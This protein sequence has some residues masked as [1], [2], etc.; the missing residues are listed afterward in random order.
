MKKLLATLL[1]LLLA[2]SLVACGGDVET[3]SET[4]LPTETE[5]ETE[6]E[7]VDTTESETEADTA[8]TEAPADPFEER[9]ETVY[10]NGANA[11]NIR[12]TPSSDTSDN[13]VGSV[14]EGSPLERTGYTDTWSRVVYNGVVC[15]AS[16]KYLSVKAP[17]VVDPVEHKTMYVKVEVSL[18]V[19]SKPWM[20]AESVA[21]FNN[22]RA[23]TLTGTV[24]EADEHGIVWARISFTDENGNAKE[25]F[26]NATYLSE[27]APLAFTD[28]DQTVFV[29]CES[30]KLRSQPGGN[31]LAVAKK[32]DT[33][34]RVGVAVVADED[35][36]VW[37]KLMYNGAP[38]YAS[39]AYLALV[40]ESKTFSVD[41]MNIN[42]SDRFTAVADPTPYTAGFD[43]DDMAITV[44]KETFAILTDAGLDINMSLVTYAQTII[45]GYGLTATV[46][47]DNGQTYFLYQSPVE[48]GGTVSILAFVYKSADAYW[49]V[50]FLT[51]ASAFTVEKATIFNYAAS[52]NFN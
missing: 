32:G 45:A 40:E 3:E 49:L 26:V 23:V 52:V 33:F 7:A 35:G 27:E 11:L 29:T 13:I 47:E 21:Y 18:T 30:L 9:S 28:V 41:G 43:S 24:A 19:R 12:S 39:S 14:A 5:S 38:C 22:G 4:D 6:S 1:A 34:Q 46:T 10:V 42:L 8:E 51:D 36:I 25:G 17:P 37:S 2:L 44:T 20:E 50:Q 16:S 31:E 48:G 15:Y